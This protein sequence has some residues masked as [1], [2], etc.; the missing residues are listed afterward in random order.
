MP[1]A[2]KLAKK[3]KYFDKLINLSETCE[4]A[5][6][7]EVDFVGSLQMQRIRTQLRGKCQVLMGK[8]TMIRTALRKRIEETENQKLQSLLD[9]VN[10]NMGFI[11]CLPGKEGALELAREILAKEKVPAAAKA[12]V[13]STVDVHIPAGPSGLEPSQISFC[14]AL[15][16]AT[17]IVKGMIELVSAV[18]LVKVGQKV[19]LSAAAFLAKLG[20]KPFEYGMHIRQVYQDGNVFDAAVLDINESVLMT[21]FLSGV[22]SIAA[23][24]R[25]IGVPTEAGLPHMFANC[26]KNVAA[27]IADIEYTFPEVETVKAFLK[28]PSAF[29]AANAGP[30]APAAGGD[31]G[32]AAAP[33]AAAVVEEEEEE[34]MDFDLFD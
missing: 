13:I 28:D 19:S 30:A 18:H 3:Q 20:L 31:G 7:V 16:I 22:S 14:Q 6:I 9:N 12:G 5:L 4:M 33:A 15:N 21:K 2:E 11:F 24:G 29:A 8:N 34:A 23:M 26:F 25:E 1:N 10:G 32:G 17:K 27:L